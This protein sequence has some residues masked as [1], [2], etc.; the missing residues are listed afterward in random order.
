MELPPSYSDNLVD[1]PNI[2][3]RLREQVW[4]Q[5]SED[6]ASDSL[7]HYLAYCSKMDRYFGEVLD[8]LEASG[9]SENTIVVF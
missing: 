1:K 8:A 5:L 3:E 7:R 2:Y 9:Q 4:D 6:E